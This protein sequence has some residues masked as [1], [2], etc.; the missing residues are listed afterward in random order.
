MEHTA[1]K[2]EMHQSNRGIEIGTKHVGGSHWIVC[3]MAAPQSAKALPNAERIVACVNACDGISTDALKEG[4][5][6][7]TYKGREDAD[8]QVASLWRERDRLLAENEAFRAV[9]KKVEL[10][11]AVGDL[12]IGAEAALMEL[13]G[14]ASRALARGAK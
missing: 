9:L 2:W 14:N 12:S 4:C 8:Y 1:G 3:D 6:A 11:G 13:A 10:F 7:A 5:I